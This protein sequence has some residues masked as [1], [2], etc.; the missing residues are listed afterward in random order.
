[1]TRLRAPHQAALLVSIPLLLAGCA[2]GPEAPGDP[3]T[4]S[5][6]AGAADGCGGITT[7]GWELTPGPPE[8]SV[9]PAPGTLIGDGS[10]AAFRYDDYR[11]YDVFSYQLGYLQDDGAVIAMGG[12]TFFTF[13]EQG[14]F[15]FDQPIFNSEADGR[16]GVMDVVLNRDGT[17]GDDGTLSAATIP[18]GRYC[19]TFDYDE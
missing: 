18:L 9:F 10:T 4:G 15:V 12:G 13:D 5:G 19:V 16:Y 7:G 11:Q 6:G 2:A 8:L 1:M 17:I 3:G 14:N